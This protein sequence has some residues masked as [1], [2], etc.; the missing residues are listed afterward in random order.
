MQISV[1]IP[2]YNAAAFVEQAVAS[3]LSQA[4]VAEVVLVEDGSTDDSPAKC[5]AL[6]EASTRVRLLRH[7]EGANRGA[8]VTR[9]LGIREASS[10][11]IAFLDADDYY[12]PGR[13]EP[14]AKVFADQADADGVYDA[15][16]THFETEQMRR[17]WAEQ[18]RNELS[19]VR[20]RVEPEHLFAAMTGRDGSFHTN[21]IVVRREL[22]E[23]TGLFDSDLRMTQDFAMWIRMAVV[24]RLYPGAID[25]AVAMR[26][27]HGENRIVQQRSDH[28][29]F[30][31]LMW[32]KLSQ[33][34]ADQ[35]LPLF[36]RQK[37]AMGQLHAWKQMTQAERRQS[38]GFSGDVRF[39]AHLAAS[40]PCCLRSQRY[41]KQVARSM[42]GSR[43]RSMIRSLPRWEAT[44]RT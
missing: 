11:F 18:G 26:R 43:V 33:W 8:A 22:F 39:L 19:T 10:N 30:A 4:E 40:Y 13:F 37:L 5:E 6:A 21:G 32:R 2:V 27:L 41:W 3:A 25:R 20:R 16:G 38:M 42:G 9:N 24:G 34:S 15:V 35:R 23:R 17:W 7:P 31:L 36:H 44:S 1:I 12:L 14:A 28:R 29:M